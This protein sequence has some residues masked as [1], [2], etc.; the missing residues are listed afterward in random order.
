MIKLSILGILNVLTKIKK[1]KTQH[2]FPSQY[3]KV[4]FA[5][6]N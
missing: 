1:K 3:F 5:D 2:E 4:Y 6:E